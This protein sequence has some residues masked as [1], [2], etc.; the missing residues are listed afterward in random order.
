MLR[1]QTRSTQTY[2]LFPYTTLVR[3]LGVV[4]EQRQLG[5]LAAGLEDLVELVVVDVAA[6]H[7][8]RAHAGA[9][10]DDARGELLRRHLQGEEGDRLSLLDRR[11]EEHTSELQSLMRISYAVFCFK[12]K[13]TKHILHNNNK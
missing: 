6:P 13:I 3:A 7:G 8:V 10:G 5:E 11:S 9:L 12:K 2:T 1:R 4:D